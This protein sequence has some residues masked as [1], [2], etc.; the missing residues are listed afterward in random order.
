MKSICLTAT[1]IFLCAYGLSAQ[2]NLDSGLVAYWPFNGNANDESGNGFN[3]ALQGGVTL[4]EDRFGNPESAYAFNGIDGRIDYPLLWG[5]GSSPDS[6]TM[7]A[8]F[9]Y[10]ETEAE[11]KIIYHGWT[12]EFQLL[13]IG[14]TV[15]T[16][17]HLPSGWYFAHTMIVPN[18]WYLLIGTWKK[19][20]KINLYLNSEL[21]D[22]TSVPDESLGIQASLYFPSIGSYNQSGGYF[23]NGII[24]D[25]RIY[26]RVLTQDEIDSLY[27]EG[28]TAIDEGLS[29]IPQKFTLSQNYPN[30]FNPSTKIKFSI[31]QKS[32]VQ[33]KVFDVLG[34]EIG[35]LFNEEKP[36]GNYDVTWNAGNLPSG[37]YFYQIK[38]GNPSTG[39]GQ[40]FVQTKKMILLK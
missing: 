5:G 29:E 31:P 32:P 26:N 18:T 23:F 2:V 27:I 33:I 16:A 40:V 30:P 24:D 17:V 6:L 25:I 35:I 11:G 37:I 36:A 8:W 22:T 38:A 12:G 9:N 7:S 15:A 1:I 19:G 3:G 10:A 34:D 4:T 39:Q 13:A 28:V 21:Q 14:D 20:E